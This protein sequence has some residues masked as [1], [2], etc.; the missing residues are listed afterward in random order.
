MII[1]I[2]DASRCDGAT[3]A[4]K[5]LSLSLGGYFGDANSCL[6]LVNVAHALLTRCSKLDLY[7]VFE[8]DEWTKVFDFSFSRWNLHVHSLNC[9]RIANFL[10]L[11]SWLHLFHFPVSGFMMFCKS[12]LN[13]SVLS[14]SPCLVPRSRWKCLLCTSMVR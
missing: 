12:E 11:M 4:S 10:A 1:H 14:G 8:S 6:W 2:P 7:G 9:H 3:V 13:K 5:S